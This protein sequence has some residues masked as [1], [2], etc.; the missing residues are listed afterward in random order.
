MQQQALNKRARFPKVQFHCMSS[1]P[2]SAF[3]TARSL[4]HPPIPNQSLR[5]GETPT[6]LL[7]G[8]QYL[9]APPSAT[10]LSAGS[11]R[12]PWFLSGRAGN[13]TMS[14]GL[15]TLPEIRPSS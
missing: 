5:S 7:Q 9:N 8:S 2:Y 4:S 10:S 12:R 11:P 3:L 6:G 13:I 15:S 1:F 14:A